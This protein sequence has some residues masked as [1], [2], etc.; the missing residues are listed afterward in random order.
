MLIRAR[1]EQWERGRSITDCMP[2]RKRV[3]DHSRVEMAQM[4]IFVACR[5]QYKLFP[6]NSSDTRNDLPAFA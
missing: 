4:G 5:G 6:Y 1:A 2:A 3:C